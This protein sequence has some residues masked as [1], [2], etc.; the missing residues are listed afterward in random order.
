VA[1][2]IAPRDGTT[3]HAD[4]R[5]APW[6]CSLGATRDA[7]SG[8]VAGRGAWTTKRSRDK[9]DRS[10]LFG[11]VGFH[12]HLPGPP[13]NYGSLCLPVPQD[14]LRARLPGHAP[15][16]SRPDGHGLTL[17]HPNIMFRPNQQN[18]EA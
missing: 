11:S 5:H 9:F 18:Q 15:A 10:P 3:P 16:R 4:G 7:G 14:A 2:A 6:A 17:P 1:A 13:P 8:E 12:H